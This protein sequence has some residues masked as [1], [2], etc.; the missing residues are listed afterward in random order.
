[1]FLAREYENSITF[2]VVTR[3]EAR[4]HYAN[5]PDAALPSVEGL[6]T[7]ALVQVPAYHF[8]RTRAPRGVIH[9]WLQ[10]P[11]NVLVSILS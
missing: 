3:E 1:V 11:P 2:G 7:R 9:Q 5:K 10:G 8:G 6:T 4:A